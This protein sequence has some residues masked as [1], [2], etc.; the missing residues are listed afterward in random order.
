MVE[1]G[2]AG[3]YNA[4][5]ETVRL[6]DFLE[7]CRA[8]SRATARFRWVDAAFL[9]D[10]AVQPWSE[11]P[12][13]VPGEAGIGMGSTSVARAIAS[14]LRFRPMEETIEDTLAW[15]RERPE[16]Y[17]LRAGMSAEREAALLQAWFKEQAE[18]MADGPDL[19]QYDYGA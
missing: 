8:V 13:W 12:L 4:T 19:D 11:M 1:E 18:E 6:G 5:G 9:L 14:G 17:E 7:A 15:A 10:H 16:D 3:V 2:A